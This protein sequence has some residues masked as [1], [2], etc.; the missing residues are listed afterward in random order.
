[1][2][3]LARRARLARSRL[4]FVTDRIDEARLD[5]ALRGGVDIVQLRE[6]DVRD[7]DLVAIAAMFA[8]LCAADGALFVLNDR[9]DLVERCGAD[10]VHVGQG[11]APVP[12]ARRH[13]GDERL[14]GLSTHSREQMENAGAADYIGVGT[15]FS[16][17]TKPGNGAAG[18]ELVRVARYAAR[19]PWFAIGGIDASNVADVAGSGASGV[20]VVR[21]IR[22][23]DDPEEAARALRSALPRGDAVVTDG[24]VLLP[25]IEWLRSTNGRARPHVHAEHLDV[26]HVLGGTLEFR[27]GDGT[28]RV[29]AGS[30]VAAPPLLVHGF[31]NPAE[32]DA[33]YL[34]LHAPGG[35]ARGGEI[36][37][38]PEQRDTFGVERASTQ[39]RPIVSAPGDGDRL[40]KPHRLAV[41][42]VDRP[43]LALLEY[44]VDGEYD[45]ADSHVHLR[46]T[47]CFHV[48][49]GALEF[50]VDG[51]DVRADPGTTVVVPPGV[52][53]E[54][55]SAAPRVRFLNV[56]APSCGFVDYMRAMDAGGDVD[57]A[58]YDSYDV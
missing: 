5:A 55:T 53:H 43:E 34:N 4:Y 46:H 15:I 11:D 18:L 2:D 45:G 47:D 20:A 49:E 17:P 14:V 33:T 12:D 44:F 27:A 51:R 7:D 6:K 38:P 36:G 58:A 54:F 13:V 32:E 48:L 3:G 41:V 29:P 8:R 30:T 21:A 25:D 22:D 31:R 9:P 57:D 10:G 37:L 23:A 1:M 40:S 56:H 39:A 52:V 26:F 24:D 42:K 50:R 35:W 19:V 28:V 16:T